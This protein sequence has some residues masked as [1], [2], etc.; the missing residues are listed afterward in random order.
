MQD[1]PPVCSPQCK[2]SYNEVTLFKILHQFYILLV[3]QLSEYLS[4]QYDHHISSTYIYAGVV[5][6]NELW[7]LYPIQ[8]ISHWSYIVFARTVASDGIKLSIRI[9][10]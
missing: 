2:N 5:S 3:R 1:L 6:G 4:I 9:L 8:E 7:R 10:L